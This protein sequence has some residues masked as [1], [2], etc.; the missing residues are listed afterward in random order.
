MEYDE[1]NLSYKIQE[2][3]LDNEQVIFPIKNDNSEG[4]WYFGYNRAKEIEKEFS[5]RRH[6]SEGLRI[7]YRRRPNEGVQPTTLWSDSKYSATEHGTALLKDFFGEQETFSYPKSIHAVE[8]CLSVAGVAYEKNSIVLDYF[9]GSGT[10]GH[11][12]I[13]L[14][15]ADEGKRKYSLVEMGE[16]FDSV[17][18]PRIKKAI[19]SEDWRTG[20]PTSRHTGISHCFK[21]IR[22]ES[23]ED[24]LNNLEIEEGNPQQG[25]FAK[26]A[27][28]DADGVQE[29]YLLRYMLDVETRE[30][31]SLL[32]IK[33]FK[34]P[35]AYKLKVKCPGSDESKEV[36]VDLLET[37][38]YL[39]GLTV[40]HIAAPQVFSPAF[41][42]DKEK[43]LQLRG[44][45]KAKT[46]GPY[47]FRTV[48]GTQPDGQKTLIIW[49]KLTEYPEKDNLVLNEW[50]KEA[51]YL[52]AENAFDCIYINGDC[53]LE[54]LKGANDTWS[55]HLLE[56][57]FHRLMFEMEDV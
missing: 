37:F 54:N 28:K 26:A 2:V 21:Y 39:I 5:A 56:A 24:T 13:I 49:R 46:E 50:F 7:Y 29:E 42:N 32:N 19:Y 30:S 3:P 14:N 55:V 31:P 34:D 48:K 4:C 1:A 38:N 57:H 17:L 33:A 43:R 6:P 23:Y 40:E 10:T 45:L 11:A 51:G 16:H 44:P 15:R 52:E 9:A 27:S 8:D 18:R 12:V 53:N 41:K 22:L 35:T 36:K 25:L 47:W 20:R